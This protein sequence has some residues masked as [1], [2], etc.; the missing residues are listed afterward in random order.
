MEKYKEIGKWI[1]TLA[2]VLTTPIWMI[3]V[4]LF[5]IVLLIWEGIASL[6][7]DLFYDW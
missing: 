6:K 4:L 1:I 3:P 5:S 2:I 7:R